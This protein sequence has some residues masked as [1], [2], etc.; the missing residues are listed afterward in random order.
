MGRTEK[1]PNFFIVGAPKCGTTALYEYLKAHPNIFMAPK[2]RHFF[3]TDSYNERESLDSYLRLFKNSSDQHRAIGEASVWYLYSTEAAKNIYKF[4]N[5]ARIIAM[6]RNPIDLVYSLHS[7]LVF[8]YEEDEREFEKAWF[9]QAERKKGNKLPRRIGYRFCPDRL[10]YSA[11]GQ[12]GAQV[13]RLLN[14]FPDEQVKLLLFD[15][16]KT[17]TLSVYEDVLSFLGVPSDR[18]T[19]FPR[20]N[21]NAV[22]RV[23]FLTMPIYNPPQIILNIVRIFK[24]K[25]GMD[26]KI[27]QIMEVL[28]K[29]NTK[30]VDRKPLSPQIRAEM[31]EAFSED[32]DKLSAILNR[33]LTHWKK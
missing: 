5:K 13:E 19:D 31:L 25:F 17:N 26:Q 20:V 3:A 24:Y 14:I 33:D 18:R 16:F 28:I 32:I 29:L 22:H 27:R 15:D 30:E 4:N 6:L 23:H 9:L 8:N 21:K 1:L 7:E 2:E 12:L 10:Q 11:V